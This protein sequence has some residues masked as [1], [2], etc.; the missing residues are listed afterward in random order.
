MKIILKDRNATR[1]ETCSVMKSGKNT[2][3]WGSKHGVN[4]AHVFNNPVSLFTGKN[5][6]NRKDIFRGTAVLSFLYDEE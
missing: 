4:G 2:A 6:H 3:Q 1:K 5:C